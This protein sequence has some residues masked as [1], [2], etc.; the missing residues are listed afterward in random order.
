MCILG[1][2]SLWSSPVKPPS[3]PWVLL[4][5]LFSL[6]VV[7]CSTTYGAATEPRASCALQPH[8]CTTRGTLVSG[9]VRTQLHCTLSFS[10]NPYNYLSPCLLNYLEE[11]S[12]MCT[13]S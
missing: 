5:L 4:G 12:H 11:S 9:N 1:I 13:A 10:C 3:Q 2:Q 7:S 6:V 8:D